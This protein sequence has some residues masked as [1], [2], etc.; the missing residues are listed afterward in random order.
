MPIVFTVD[1]LLDN[2]ATADPAELERAYNTG[3]VSLEDVVEAPHLSSDS[4]LFVPPFSLPPEDKLI[5]LP[6][7]EFMAYQRLDEMW[8]DG[9]AGKIAEAEARKQEEREDAERLAEREAA[10]AAAARKQ[11]EEREAVEAAAARKQKE[12]RE[13]ALAAS[14]RKQEEK[15]EAVLAERGAYL[16]ATRAKQ[17]RSDRGCGTWSPATRTREQPPTPVAVSSSPPHALPGAP[18]FPS[19]R[20]AARGAG[21]GG[22]SDEREGAGEDSDSAV[23]GDVGSSGRC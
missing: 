5:L 2:I 1:N 8:C 16:Q 19:Y 21:G 7:D 15:S 11:E 9:L 14:P 17:G 13:A 18:W 20:L 10:L 6:H 4:P 3:R 22:F 23:F 12:E